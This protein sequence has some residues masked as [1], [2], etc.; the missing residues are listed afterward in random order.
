ME[1]IDL[2]LENNEASDL[3]PCTS[4]EV[5]KAND[6]DIAYFIFLDEGHLDE[7]VGLLG[8]KKGKK[9]TDPKSWE[10]RHV[11]IDC[12]DDSGKTDDSEA[13]ATHGEFTYVI[14][15]H[16]G[17]KRG[18]LQ[19]QRQW[20]ARFRQDDVVS[21]GENG[22]VQMQVMRDKFRL[23]RAHQRRAG[24]QR[25]RADP[26]LE[27]DA[28]GLRQRR[29]Q[30]REQEGQEVGQAPQEGR[31]RLQ[32]RGRRL[33]A[34]RQPAAGLRFP[35]AATGAPIFVEVAGV[36]DWFEGKKF[37][38]VEAVWQLDG[39]GSAEEPVGFR[40]MTYR[41]NNEYDCILGNLDAVDKKS[42]LIDNYPE[43]AGALS[44]HWRFKIDR[45]VQE[46]GRQGQARQDDG[47][48]RA[49]HRGHCRGPQRPHA[50][51]ERRGRPR[52]DALLQR[53]LGR[54]A[55]RRRQSSP[56]CSTDRKASWGTS[57]RPTCFMRFLPAFCFS[58]SLRLREMSPP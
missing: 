32:H 38:T 26:P 27:G 2:E 33:P 13:S 18:P 57:M 16:Y 10:H 55:G 19:V 21:A 40:A 20:M 34:Q 37:P 41:G 43:G 52:G 50:L 46:Q 8:H 29:A 7:A 44:Q 58:S 39:P 6:W 5:L 11:P 35:V 28:E 9:L 36:P 56:S 48:R 4:K 47:R 42:M 53:Q 22:G 51:R 15:S 30:G 3:A 31:L 17:K 23:H 12:G 49:A 54:T 45:P 24:G 14:A 25:H 1:S